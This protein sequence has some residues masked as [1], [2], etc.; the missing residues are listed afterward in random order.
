[1]EGEGAA[2]VKHEFGI[3]ERMLEGRQWLLGGE[4]PTVAD[5]YLFAVSRWADY[6]K[7]FDMEAAYPGV[8][9]HCARMRA[10]PAVQFALAVE[11]DKSAKGGPVYKGHVDIADIH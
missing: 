10:Q 5:A 4:K 8:Y 11:Q 2:A 9:R 1:M 7:V 3:V 6:H